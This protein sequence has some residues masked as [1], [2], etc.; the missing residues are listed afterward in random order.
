MRIAVLVWFLLVAQGAAAQRIVVFDI[1]GTLTPNVWAMWH[2][3]RDAARAAAV[4]ADAG[5]TVVYLSA[6]VPLFQGGVAGWL[7][8][9]EFPPGP[10]YLTQTDADQ[11]DHAGF[12]VRVLRGL[13]ADGEIIAAYGDSTTDFAAYAGVGIAP[14]RVFA[15]RRWGC[16]D[17]QPGVWQGCYGGWD[18]LLPG[19]AAIAE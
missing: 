14:E 1:D 4:Y 9:H 6:R 19:I 2:A 3:R 18:A 7:T 5:V 8:A 16:D 17:C 10:V 15:L 12:K 13:Q 11:A